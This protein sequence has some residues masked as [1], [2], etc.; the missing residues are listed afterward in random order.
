MGSKGLWRHVLGTAIA[1]KPCALLAGVP[2][3]ADGKTPAMEK[4]VELKE[5]K[6]Q[7]FE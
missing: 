4:Q 2:V 7:E 3:V 5:T 6:I 1:L